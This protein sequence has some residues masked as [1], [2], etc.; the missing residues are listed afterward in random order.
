M[1]TVV[2]KMRACL[3][4]V[5]SILALFSLYFATASAHEL[6]PAVAHLSVD[7]D[8]I[9]IELELVLEPLIADLDLSSIFDTNESPKAALHDELRALTARALEEQLRAE[10][11]R[12]AQDI[13]ILSGE[14]RVVPELSA[15]EIAEIGDVELPRESK[16]V[17]SAALPAGS[18]P[19][20]F[21]WVAENGGLA[22]Q[23]MT[24]DPDTAYSAYLTGGQ[25]SDPIPREGASGQSW[26]SVFGNYIKI[27]FEHIVPKGLDH[28][29]FV[30]GLFFFSLQMRPLLWQISAFTLAHTVTL[31]LATLGLVNLPATIVEPL[32][33]ASIVYVAV[34]NIF[35]RRYNQWRTAIVFGFGLLHGL[36]FASVLGDIGLEPSRFLTG[37]IGFN[38]GVEIGQLSVIAAAFL[39]VASWAGR[40]PWYQS[41]IATPAS[42][43]I[44][45]VG[46]WWF[47]ERVFL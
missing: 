19:I 7:A 22:V 28:I 29:L 45:L 31:A 43:A 42:V 15:V 20:K 34:E 3:I 1:K 13:T 35:H 33:A 41:V 39:L 44:A 6:R 9:E 26:L 12:I 30:L 32:I 27:G 21:G 16:I 47:I 5:S 17:L 23:Q 2:T 37:L 18:D 36:G 10:W 4:A 38:I 11:P 8:R 25:L 46:A 24:D 14:T 40:K